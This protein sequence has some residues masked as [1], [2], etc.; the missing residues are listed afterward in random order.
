MACSS[1]LG[2][3][4]FTRWYIALKIQFY[5]QLQMSNGKWINRCQMETD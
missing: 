2:I 1:S 5:L 4:Q 3:T